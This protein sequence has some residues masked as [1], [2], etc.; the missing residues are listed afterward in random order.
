GQFV[1]FEADLWIDPAKNNARIGLFAARERPRQN[2]TEIIAEASLS[3]HKEGGV[4]LRF[5]RQGQAPELRDMQQPFPTG[6]WVRLKLERTGESSETA[7]TLFL[8]GIPLVENQPMPSLGVSKSPLLVGVFV[9]G[10]T[11]R[12]VLVR[13]DN[14]SVVTRI[15]P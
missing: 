12:E 7:V 6:Q 11:G 1:S 15:S 5:V 9:E 10:D 13:V 14:V 3:R 2:D 4:Q 8:D